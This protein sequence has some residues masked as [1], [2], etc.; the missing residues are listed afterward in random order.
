[1]AEGRVKRRLAAILAADVAGYS[2]LMGEDEE[3]TL[4]ALTAH[5]TEHIE[6]CIA[7]HGGRVVKTTGDGLLAEF[8]SVVDAVRC[9]VAFQEGMAE[10]ESD[11]PAARRIAFRIGVNLGDVM[12]QDDDVYGDGVNV[13]ARLEGLAAPGGICVS[14]DVV[15]QIRGAKIEAELDDLGPQEFKNI[16]EPV[17]AFSVRPVEAPPPAGEPG[18]G[19]TL[20][21]PDKPSIAVLPFQNMSGDPEQEYFAD[22]ITEDMITALSRIRWFFVIARN[23]SFAYKGTS[24]NVIDAARDLGVRYV[25][26]GSVRKAGGRVRISAQLIDGGTGNHVW[27]ERYDRQLEDIFDLQDEITQTIVGAIEPELGKAERQRARL[28]RPESL[29]SWDVYQQGMSR[30]Y[31]L[32]KD[33]L[34]QALTLFR[35]AI[36]MDADFAAAHSGIAEVYYHALVYGLADD[37]ERCRRDVLAPALRA[38]ELNPDDAGTR[39]ALGRAYVLRRQSQAAV[40]EFEIA[41]ELNP[42]LALAHYGLGAALVFSGRSEAAIPHLETAIRLSPR[43]PNM[44]SFLVRIA[45]AYLFMR[46]H[47]GAVE[48]ARKALREPH[49][50]WSRHAILISALAHLG[51][52]DEARAAL[53][54]LM[55]LRPDFSSRYLTDFAPFADDD[56]TRHLLDGLKQAGLPQ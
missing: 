54:E 47:E 3:G 18:P 25:L 7:E 21:L 6:P 17:H 36:E 2:R 5:L 42:S 45:N 8:A 44:G 1:M 37:P 40:P 50:Q 12:V 29:A 19:A 48:W 15:R 9:A 20:L 13:A 14:G 30:L 51:R 43:D 32:S 10:R 38:V 55:R 46:D 28:K 53:A 11:R 39:C 16:A 31:A 41:L 52:A 33:S 27:A 23:S 24:P 26:E 4:A 56:D 34:D 22:G 49:F 35:R